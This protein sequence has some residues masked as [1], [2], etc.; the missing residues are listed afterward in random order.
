[1]IVFRGTMGRVVATILAFADV[2]GGS[3]HAQPLQE[4]TIAQGSVGFGT[5]ALPLAQQLGLFEKHGLKAKV[6]VMD[7]GSA[8]TTAMLSG[9][10]DAA[11]SGGAELVAALGHG[12]KAGIVVDLYSGLAGTLVLAK[13]TIDRLGV[14]ASAPVSERLK[15]LNGLVIAT[16]SATSSYTV[17]LKGAAAKYG[18]TVHL[19]YMAPQ[20]MA[21]AFDAG[22]IQGY[23][24]GAPTWA[25]PV[26]KG[27]GVVWI[28]GPKG[29]F[30]TE[31]TP[32]S[33]G[34]LQAL[35]AYAATHPDI[36]RRLDDVFAE[37]VQDIDAH[38]ADVKAALGRAYPNL[39]DKTLEI[40]YAS[41]SDAWRAKILTPA[42]VQHDI[43]FVKSTGVDLPQ[44]GSVDP[45]A[46][47]LRPAN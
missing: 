42:D 33:N 9:S 18:A 11:L 30:P 34:N 27:T 46:V 6:I 17:S 14:S 16:P 28:S 45:A 20:A 5:A 2:C 22:A 38:P 10:V 4:V 12:Q 47:L 8:A 43:D 40:L 35:T 25:P 32:A 29:E 44:I 7:S 21:S 39:D 15:A 37:L 19:T 31:F 1:M 36:V 13:S 24:A 41:E 26:L 23:I 3:A